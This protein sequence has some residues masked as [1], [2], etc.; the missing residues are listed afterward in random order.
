MSNW[1]EEYLDKDADLVSKIQQLDGLSADLVYDFIKYMMENDDRKRLFVVA[2]P[3]M[4]RNLTRKATDVASGR[5]L[6]TFGTLITDARFKITGARSGVADQLSL[7]LIRA[8]GA[9]FVAAMS[10]H[11]KAASIGPKVAAAYSKV[12]GKTLMDSSKLT[13]E[14]KTIIDQQS[15]LREALKSKIAAVQKLISEKV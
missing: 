11:A 4:A 2:A 1:Y 3:L 15:D 8:S 13:G 12:S 6:A 5:I 10:G 9:L 14:A 7:S